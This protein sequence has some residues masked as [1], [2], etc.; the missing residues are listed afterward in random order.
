MSGDATSRGRSHFFQPLPANGKQDRNAV[1]QSSQ[2]IRNWRQSA[3]R[4]RCCALQPRY[5]TASDCVG[6]PVEDTYM[7]APVLPDDLLG[8][9]DR[10]SDCSPTSG[11]LMK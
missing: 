11:L 3:T 2:P 8:N 1:V 4:C 10:G 9:R 7:V 6:L 5:P